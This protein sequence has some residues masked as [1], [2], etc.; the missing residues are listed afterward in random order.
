MLGI[1][2]SDALVLLAF[3]A[4]VSGITLPVRWIVKRF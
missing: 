1:G 2:F 4:I 3:V